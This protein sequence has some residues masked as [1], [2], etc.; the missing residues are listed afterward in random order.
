M[1][2]R[3]LSLEVIDVLPSVPLGIRRKHVG[4]MSLAL[5]CEHAMDALQYLYQQ[6]QPTH[7]ENVAGYLRAIHPLCARLYAK[8]RDLPIRHLLKSLAHQVY[9][10][11]LHVAAQAFA[12]VVQRAYIEFSIPQLTK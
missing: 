7:G 10:G 8:G 6:L 2:I 3:V 4:I 5:F 12:K 11:L 1:L 9:T